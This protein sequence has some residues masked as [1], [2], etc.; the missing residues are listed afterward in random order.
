M[1][2]ISE[3]T[4]QVKTMMMRLVIGHYSDAYILVK[5]SGTIPG[6]RKDTDARLVDKKSNIKILCTIYW[7]H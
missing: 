2:N 1:I 5:G 4:T 7:Q 3:D 6:A